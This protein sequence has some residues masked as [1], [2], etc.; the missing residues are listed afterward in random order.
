MQR[1]SAETKARLRKVSK[2]TKIRSLIEKEVKRLR[3]TL[4]ATKDQATKQWL[5]RQL[6]F[7]LKQLHQHKAAGRS[8]KR[9]RRRRSTKRRRRSTKRRRNSRK[10]RRSTKRR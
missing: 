2:D 3:N 9:R 10:R 8:T 6:G 4:K 5:E 1:I 7:A